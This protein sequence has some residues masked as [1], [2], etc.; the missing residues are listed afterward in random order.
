MAKKVKAKPKSVKCKD[1]KIVMDA[2]TGKISQ[3]CADSK[4][5]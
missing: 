3:Q 5:K 2:K 4:K 1:P